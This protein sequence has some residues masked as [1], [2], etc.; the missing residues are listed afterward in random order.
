MAFFPDLLR[1]RVVMPDISFFGGTHNSL[2]AGQRTNVEILYEAWNQPL[3]GNAY[4]DE[5][6][7]KR[8][9]PSELYSS[10]GSLVAYTDTI[11]QVGHSGGVD[12]QLG[13]SKILGFAGIGDLFSY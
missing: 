11:D 3:H 7:C 6:F 12:R 9:S 10:Q 4:H 5:P 8:F 1:T 13:G 2:D